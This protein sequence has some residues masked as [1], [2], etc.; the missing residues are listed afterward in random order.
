MPTKEDLHRLVDRLPD[1][2]VPAAERYL[3]FLAVAGHDPLLRALAN[4]PLD[5]QPESDE[6]R[7]AVG[8]ARAELERGE[9]VSDA[10]LRAFL[11]APEDDEPFTEEDEAA[12]AEARAD[13]AG[14]DTESWES[15]RSRRRARQ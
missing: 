5:D 11:S 7:A 15:Y 13:I 12:I 9:V 2:E 10:V 14:G 3:E 8:E 4:A 1:S 6:E